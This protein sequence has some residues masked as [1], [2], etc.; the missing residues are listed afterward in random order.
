[1]RFICLII[2]LSAISFNA[3]K[4]HHQTISSLGNAASSSR[5]LYVSQSIGQQSIAGSHSKNGVVYVQGFQ[6]SNWNKYLKKSAETS[7]KLNAYPNPFVNVI[8]FQFSKIIDDSLSISIYD[9]SGRQV[10]FLKKYVSG[11]SLEVDLS[12]IASGS[13]LVQLYTGTSVFYKKILKQ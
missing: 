13:Y 5:G 11:N 8:T 3:Q 12:Q 4:L 9:T 6:Q 2:F 7:P 10:L 1:M